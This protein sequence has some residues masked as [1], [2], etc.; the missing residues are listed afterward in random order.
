MKV[1]TAYSQRDFDI[2]VEL[3]MPDTQEPSNSFYDDSDLIYNPPMLEFEVEDDV[4]DKY[5]LAFKPNETPPGV[6]GG[7][8]LD[9]GVDV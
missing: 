7:P 5:I 3:G 4:A 6:T 8:L 1:V 9:I 2:L